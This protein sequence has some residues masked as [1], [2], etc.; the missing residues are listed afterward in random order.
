MSDDRELKEKSGEH[1]AGD[2]GQIL[3][4]G[5]FLV[6]W[7]IDSFF[8]RLSTFPADFV[9]L[10]SRLIA[11]GILL[12]LGFVLAGAAHSIVDLAK[13]N[14]SVRTTGVFRYVRHPLY[15]GSIL[16]YVSLTVATGSLISLAMTAVIIIFYNFIA[17]YEEQLLVRRHGVEYEQYMNRTGKWIPKL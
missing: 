8:L 15:L 10:S 4:L 3:L 7:V 5:L 16:F 6:V 11:A 1:P 12:T 17:G 13:Q 2:S 14:G 9:S